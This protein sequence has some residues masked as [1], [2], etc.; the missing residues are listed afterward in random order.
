MKKFVLSAVAI[1]FAMFLFSS[2]GGG[3]VE[4]DIVGKWEIKSADLSNLDELVVELAESFGLGDEEIEQMKE[5]MKTGMSEEFIGS[6]I[7]FGEDKTFVTPDGEGEWSYDADKKVIVVKEGDTEYDIIVDKLS[8][9][10]LEMTMSFDD[11]GM[12]FKIAMTL[13][14]K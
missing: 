9:D 11:S 14:R 12:E 2:C 4:K 7:E 3:N 1:V 8:G 10:N 13:V 5:E 6:T